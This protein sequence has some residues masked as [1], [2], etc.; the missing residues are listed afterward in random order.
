M[1]TKILLSS[2]AVFALIGCGN[3]SSSSTEK[4]DF[5]LKILHVNDT[6]SHLEPIRI[7]AQIDGNKTYVYAGGYAKVSQYVKDIKAKNKNTLFLHAGDAVQGTLYYT[8]TKGK[9]DVEAFN[10]MS[11]DAMTPGNHAWDNG[12][13]NFYENFASLANFPILSANIDVSK[14]ENLSTLMK[15]YVIKDFNGEKVAIVG[16]TVDASVISSPGPT[17]KFLNYITAAENTV[18]EL[19]NQGINKIIFLTHIGYNNDQFLA[20]QVKGIDVI[21]GGHSHTFLGNFDNLGLTTKG[22]Y[23]TK[24]G[25]TLVVTAWKW[26]QVV[27]NLDVTFDKNGKIIKYS[28]TP[29]MLVDDKFLRKNAEGKKVEVNETVKKQIENWIS[30]QNN[31]KIESQDPDVVAVIN[32]Y[33]PKVDELKHKVIGEANE[34]LI[35]VRLPGKVDED[36][37][38]KLD[39]GSMIAPIVAKAMYERAMKNGG[40]DFSL[41]NAGGVRITIPKGDITVGEV[42]QLLPFGNTLVTLDLNGS[43]IKT[44]I[45]NAVDRSLIKEE[46]TGAFPYLGNAKITIDKNK[47]LG[48]RIVSFKIK[49]KENG[50]WV[51][52]D[53]N[54]TYKIATN[55]YV[56]NGG[57]YYNE[58][59]NYATNKYDTGFVDSDTF[60]NYVKEKKII[61]PLPEDEIPVT[62]K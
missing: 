11:L 57:D 27:G 20:S 51:D 24:V 31:I 37:G 15:K 5:T 41:Q 56:A 38:E 40:C 3:S 58:L 7:K 28:G 1:K 4:P 25:D 48:Q 30:K 39:H 26:A 53:L 46:N 44:M 12:A 16:E 54:K 60:M 47:P 10:K 49:D 18:K 52:L 33:K 35:H 17:I 59:K 21:V 6:H 9:A 50:K 34:T 55:S 13:S 43:T 2:I 29:V 8:L 45:E 32:Q 62:V 22:K 61:S 23:P 19:E 42:Y 36:T 14:D